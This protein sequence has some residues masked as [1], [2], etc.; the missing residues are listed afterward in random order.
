MDA[1]G[2]A[3]RLGECDGPLDHPGG[4]VGQHALHLL[5][6]CGPPRFWRRGPPA[7][8]AK[9]ERGGAFVFL[10]DD[11]HLAG[12]AVEDSVS[13]R[14]RVALEA[15]LLVAEVAPRHVFAGLGL[16]LRFRFGFDL[17]RLGDRFVGQLGIEPLS[18]RIEALALAQIVVVGRLAVELLELGDHQVGTQLRCGLPGGVHAR[19]HVLAVA[20]HR[21]PPIVVGA[22]DDPGVRI[23]PLDDGADRLEPA[24]EERDDDR[25]LG[26]EVD[27]PTGRPSLAHVQHLGLPVVFRPDRVV[28]APRP[29]GLPHLLPDAVRPYALQADEFAGDV[30]HRDQ[31]HRLMRLRVDGRSKHRYGGDALF[32]EV[33]MVRRGSLGRLPQLLDA[34]RRLY[35]VLLAQGIGLRL[36]DAHLFGGQRLE[37]LHGLAPRRIVLRPLPL[38]L[39]A[40]VAEDGAALVDECLEPPRVALLPG[41]AGEAAESAVPLDLLRMQ[42]DRGHCLTEFGGG[43]PHPKIL[44]SGS[45]RASGGIHP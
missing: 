29:A 5:D 25:T 32:L 26:G 23:L 9:H 30:P 2:S 4:D 22:Y 3:L 16:G 27:R 37:V 10:P 43:I 28:E 1:A 36:L 41:D 12:H 19:V 6:Q 8:L 7:R 34:R 15:F 38:L 17:P 42:T 39:R 14:R 31:Q 13:E 20:G 45:T 18:Y 33:R 24:V 35:R 44:P 40:I 21:R 11:Q